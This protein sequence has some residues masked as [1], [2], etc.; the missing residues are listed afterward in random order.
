[1]EH[2]QRI[3]DKQMT[4]MLVSQATQIHLLQRQYGRY[5]CV[6]EMDHIMLS[7]HIM[8]DTAMI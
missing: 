6:C 8:Y 3:Y 4:E 5:K 1:M 7:C 2:K